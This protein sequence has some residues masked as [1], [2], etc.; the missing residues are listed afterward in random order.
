MHVLMQA[1]GP[2]S[3]GQDVH[4]ALTDTTRE[5]RNARDAKV[6]VAVVLLYTGKE[7][8]NVRG[9]LRKS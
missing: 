1:G 8:E 3:H 4:G 6:R 2:S 9:P 7:A 5:G